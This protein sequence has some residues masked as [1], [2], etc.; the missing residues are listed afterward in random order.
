VPVCVPDSDQFSVPGAVWYARVA[1]CRPLWTLPVPG[2]AMRVN[3]TTAVNTC[4]PPGSRR[5][6]SRS[7]G[8]PRPLRQR[9][10]VGR[11]P[12]YHVESEGYH[13]GD[14]TWTCSG[15]PRPTVD[16]LYAGWF[17]FAGSLYTSGSEFGPD[18]HTETVRDDGTLAGL[19]SP[20]DGGNGADSGSTARVEWS[21]HA[22]E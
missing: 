20:G 21:L 18:V 13:Y 7:L 2:F 15:T 19:H 5:L 4:V 11:R 17:D 14:I 6:W 1:S 10:A 12:A 8:K 9:V 22:A 3:R 16:G